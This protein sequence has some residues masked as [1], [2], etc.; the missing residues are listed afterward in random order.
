MCG[1]L[2]RGDPMRTRGARPM[3]LSRQLTYAFSHEKAMRDLWRY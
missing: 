1:S 2:G 3:Q